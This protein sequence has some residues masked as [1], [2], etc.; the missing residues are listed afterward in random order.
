MNTN[1]ETGT[2][3]KKRQENKWLLIFES[4]LTGL[5]TGLVITVFRLSISYL[6]NSRIALYDVIRTAGALGVVLALAG[7]AL[8][9]LFIGFIIT[10]WPMIKGGGVAQIEGVFMQK[11]QFSPLSEL[12]LKFIGGVLGIGLGLSM[13]REGPMSGMPLSGWENDHLPNGY[14]L[15]LPEPP[16]D[17]RQ[18]SMPLLPQSFLQLKTFITI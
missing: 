4:L 11:L 18:P 9:G 6:K 3:L 5:L 16:P 15:L 7:L 2:L 10:K 17:F 13:G 1:S 12:P 14:V 8:V